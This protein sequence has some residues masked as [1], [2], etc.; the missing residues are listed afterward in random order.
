MSSSSFP[1]RWVFA[2]LGVLALSVGAWVVA[3]WGAENQKNLPG[4]A[5]AL[6]AP[7][8]GP[9]ARV[10]AEMEAAVRA[11]LDDVNANG[12]VAGKRIE[13]KVFDDGGDPGTAAKIAAQIAASPD[14]VA[15][16]G[17]SLSSTSLAAAPAYQAAGLAA[18]TP[19]ATNPRLTEKHANYFSSIYSDRVQGRFMADYAHLALTARTAVAVVAP[20]EYA[21]DLSHAFQEQANRLG[22]DVRQPLR[23]TA[24]ALNSAEGIRALVDKLRATPVA[25]IAL[26]ADQDSAFQIVRALREGGIVSPILGPDSIGSKSFAARFADLPTEIERPGFYLANLFVS[27]PFIADVSNLEARRLMQRIEHKLGALENWVAPYAYDAAKV[28]VAALRRSGN[29]A[30]R[31]SVLANL[32]RMKGSG[33][34]LDGAVGPIHFNAGGA[35]ERPVT[36]GVFQGG[37]VSSLQQLQL[38]PVDPNAAPKL[39]SIVYAGI[40]PKSF[41]EIDV[42]SGEANIAFDIWFRYQGELDLGEIE[43]DNAL[44][45]VRLAKADYET[46][47]NGIQYKRFSVSERF[48]LNFLGPPRLYPH[49]MLQIVLHQRLNR[50]KDVALVPDTLGLPFTA[51]TKFAGYLM[52]NL[53][54]G[55]GWRLATAALESHVQYKPTL[56]DPQFLASQSAMRQQAGFV[57][58]G[59]IAPDA[60]V[61]RRRLDFD[62]V[63]VIVPF[64]GLALVALYL[65][66]RRPALAGN[67]RY[68]FLAYLVL[69]LATLFTTESA[70]MRQLAVSENRS[71]IGPALILFDCLWWFVPAWLLNM[72][73]NRFVWVPL[74]AA[75]RQTVPQVVKH[76]I[77]F[78]IFALTFFG[79]VAFVFDRQITSLLATSGLVAMIIGLAIQMNISHIFSGIA[80]NIERPF[81]TGD[82][83]KIGDWPVGKVV[84]ISWRSTKLETFGNTLVSIPNSKAAENRIENFT[85]PNIA[86][87]I[88]VT[89][90]FDLEHDPERL[91]KLIYDAIRIVK[92]VDGRERID[93]ISVEH[94]EVDEDGQQFLITFDCVNRILQN[95]QKHAVLV[96][97]YK[98]LARFGVHPVSSNEKIHGTGIKTLE[99]LLNRIEIFAPLGEQGRA[100]LLRH[101]RPLEFGGG[102][103]IVEQAAP[104][105]SLF[106]IAEG[107]ASIEVTVA[108]TQ[109]T[110]EVDRIAAGDFFGEMTLLTGEPRTATVRA[111]DR[112]RV[113][114]IPRQALEPFLVNSTEM[115]RQIS[116]IMAGRVLNRQT[117]LDANA[118]SFESE[119]QKIS[120]SLLSR[121]KRF[122]MIPA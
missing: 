39:K 25:L 59:E 86:Y 60:L 37:L 72:A 50:D 79:I 64:F 24:S 120:G 107:V 82:W 33:D 76:F 77:T 104:G 93:F 47:W 32:Q 53:K 14:I 101:A 54:E 23:V 17:H 102:E 91:T 22:M 51:G 87:R 56:G 96:S 58:S 9:S 109:Q 18:I 6:A 8:S 20:G 1:R 45:P 95:A 97:I 62:Y 5:I 114:E 66:R 26:F 41:S 108:E 16:V 67:P 36:I 74:E 119:R 90:H 89:L 52:E 11:V 44:K 31:H 55:G 28:I 12:G 99:S 103:S 48:K 27:A 65:A 34:T 13:L 100:E 49:Q 81:R 71:L 105:D 122:F 63:G 15:V 3:H 111:I 38:D 10:G 85:Y 35:A 118:A 57:F 83:I 43:F 30:L 61:L 113:Y 73:I 21:E 42:H 70:L 121:I 40:Q 98:M 75:T 2:A 68:V 80:L 7:L 84:D 88:F 112:V 115:T 92:S 106:L 94:N 110:I 117:R 19:A 29:D 4:V 69:V 46:A 116:E 78:L